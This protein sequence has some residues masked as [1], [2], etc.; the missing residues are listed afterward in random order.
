[1]QDSLLQVQFFRFRS[2]TFQLFDKEFVMNF[3]LNKSLSF[4]GALA[5][6]LVMTGCSSMDMGS[7]SAKTTAT[8]SAGGSE[9]Q[10]ANSGLERCSQALGT[11]AV[12]E[13]QNADWYRKVSNEYKL[14][15]TAPVLRLLAQQSN[16]FVVVERGRTMQNMAGERSLA[17]S[18][19][20][21]DGSNMGKGQMVA[22]DFTLNPTI[23]F[24]DDTGGMKGSIGGLLRKGGGALG[25]VASG[26]AGSVKMKDASTLLTLIDNRSG[27]QLAIA[28]GSSR[29]MDFDL[30]AAFKSVGGTR[31]LN[32]SLGGYSNTPEGKVIAAALTDSFNNLVKAVKNSKTQTVKGGLGTGKGGLQVQQN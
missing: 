32:T 11:M 1:L 21:R 2:K 17:Q 29:N 9:A 22:A 5:S 24:S 25:T 23:T 31:G 16:C 30:G 19:E 3:P 13:D 4:L 18:G 10:N 12:V 26:L 6:L 20:M 7:S 8:G 14:G 15:S 27:V 28:E